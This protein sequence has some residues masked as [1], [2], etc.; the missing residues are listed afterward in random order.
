MSLIL[1]ALNRSRQ[2]S[3]ELPGLSS[4]HTVET[5]PKDSHLLQWLLVS[6][7]GLAVL[8]IGWLLIE[9]TPQRVALPAEIAAQTA[10]P[11]A[12]PE[13]VNVGPPIP[14]AGSMVTM[15]ATRATPSPMTW[16]PACVRSP[17]S[18]PPITSPARAPR[19][20][21][22]SWRKSRQRKVSPMAARWRVP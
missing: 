4:V 1:D 20:S 13:F 11:A 7:L 17:T 5:P 21:R 19:R 6:A 22:R 16:S 12:A 3:E 18:R 15:P 10:K 14:F 2:D 9:R 8:A